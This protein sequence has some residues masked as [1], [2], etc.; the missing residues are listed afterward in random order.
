[1]NNPS[2]DLSKGPI[3][4]MAGHSVAANLIML[5]C[6]IGG[7]MFLRNIKQEVFP[8]FG[9]DAIRIRLP[10]FAAGATGTT[11]VWAARGKARVRAA[12]APKRQGITLMGLI[13]GLRLSG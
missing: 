8:E 11:S 6:L 5:A 9:V 2:S 7:F 10:F 13:N 4:W 3:A 1:M 12:T